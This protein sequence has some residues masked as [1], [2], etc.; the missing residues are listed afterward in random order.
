MLVAAGGGRPTSS[1]RI[2]EQ[3][4]ARRVDGLVLATARGRNPVLTPAWRPACPDRAGQ[5][6]EDEARVSAVITD[7]IGGMRL[8]V[9][10]LVGL[11]H[12][13]IGHLAGPED[14]STGVLRRQGFEEAMQ[15][16]GLDAGA[17]VTASRL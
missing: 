17:V 9:E 3:L 13:R 15:A 14:L 1:I 4:I 8:A 11:G 5:S 16:A 2:V 12:R 7:D 6:G 10:H